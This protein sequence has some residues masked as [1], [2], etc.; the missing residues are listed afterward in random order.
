[1]LGFPIRSGGGE[2]WFG[3]FFILHDFHRHFREHGHGFFVTNHFNDVRAHRVFR[4]DPVNRFNGRTFAGIGAPRSNTFINTGVQRAPERVFNGVP[5][6]SFAPSSNIRT[7]PQSGATGAVRQPSASGFKAVNPFS[8]SR[9]YSQPPG[10][11]RTF[12]P[13]SGAPGG[14]RAVTAPAGRAREGE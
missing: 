10:A 1:M 9:V 6:R 12:T 8:A 4:V 14:G 7:H 5:S 2:F 13:R 3:G 11:G